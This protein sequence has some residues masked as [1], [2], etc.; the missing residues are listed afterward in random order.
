MRYKDLPE[1]EQPAWRVRELGAPSLSIS[2]LLAIALWVNDSDT[3]NEIA[4]LVAQYG[5]L[6]RIPRAR[7]LEIKNVG[8]RCADAIAAVVE[9]GRREATASGPTLT[10]INSPA[11]AAGC[12]QYEMSTLDH[13][14]LWVILLDR[15][16]QVRKIVKLYKGSVNSSQVR[17]GE[18]F[19]E[20]I[21]EQASGV[22][23]VHNHPSGD[24]TPSPD[25][26]SVTRAIIQAGKLLDI[27]V[28]DHLVIGTGRW[29]SLKERG[30]GFS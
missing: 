19:K 27:D 15:R 28:L 3:T 26:V 30:L 1:K 6:A 25:D 4:Q 23:I 20:A 12:V 5:R 8:E 11:D 29:V 17:V 13:E 7:L 21:P 24:P 16:N 22:V 9:I 2:E 10:A 14:E 18:I